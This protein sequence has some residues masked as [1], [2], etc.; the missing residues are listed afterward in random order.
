MSGLCAALDNNPLNP[1]V[2]PAPAAIISVFCAPVFLMFACLRYQFR[3]RARNLV[4]TSPASPVVTFA[5]RD[6][7][8]PLPPAIPTRDSLTRRG[9]TRYVVVSFRL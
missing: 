1:V 2:V 5:D 3:V 6:P 4:G 9:Y 8:P 7:I